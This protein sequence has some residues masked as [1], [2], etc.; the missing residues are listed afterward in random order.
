MS[1]S[2]PSSGA[3]VLFRRQLHPTVPRQGDRTR[4]GNCSPVSFQYARFRSWPSRRGGTSS[5]VRIA[6][7]R[8]PTSALERRGPYR[9]FH[10]AMPAL[11][12]RAFELAAVRVL[13]QE[14]NLWLDLRIPPVG[15]AIQLPQRYGLP[16]ADS[17][18]PLLKV[19][20]RGLGHGCP[21]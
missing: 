19:H 18:T 12:C 9:P 13:G 1:A 14:G 3:F 4:I 20:R 15:S 5:R 8:V 6:T 10:H 7:G 17:A 11:P 16:R 21:P 2:S